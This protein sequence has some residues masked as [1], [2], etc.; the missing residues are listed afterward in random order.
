MT[1]TPAEPGLSRAQVKVSELGLYRVT[2]GTLS[3]LVNVG[4]ENP[5]EFQ[6][7]V[8]T[9]EKLRPLAEATGGTVR[10]IGAGSGG[11]ITL[12]R[13]VAMRDS[14]IYGG[15]DYAA[16][17]K[18]RRGASDGRRD[19]AARNRAHRPHLPLRQRR[20]KLDFRRTRRIAPKRTGLTLTQAFRIFLCGRLLR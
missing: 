2:D 1:L 5:R 11:D 14:P 4:P 8:S 13:I 15:S 16:I 10:R 20:R 19:R 6:E 18:D 7:V 3:A 17:K 9:T 12:P